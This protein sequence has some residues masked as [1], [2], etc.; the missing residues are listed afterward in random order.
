MIR[1][2]PPRRDAEH[3]RQAMQEERARTL[4][5]EAGRLGVSPQRGAARRLPPAAERRFC[6]IA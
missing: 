3:T 6:N 5:R 1:D 4:R 2:Q